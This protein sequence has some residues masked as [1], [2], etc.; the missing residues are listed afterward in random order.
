MN[1]VFLT[2]CIYQLVIRHIDPEQVLHSIC[3]TRTY[4]FAI[5]SL[6]W[7]KVV[8]RL[9]GSTGYLF[10]GLYTHTYV[11]TYITTL[12]A[13]AYLFPAL[14]EPSASHYIQGSGG[15]TSLEVL[16]ENRFVL[17]RCHWWV[18]LQTWKMVHTS[19][20]FWTCL[21]YVCLTEGNEVPLIHWSQCPNVCVVIMKHEFE[22]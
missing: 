3:Y 17:I 18:Y 7:N 6:L 20:K 11:H 4:I 21:R 16:E 2:L 12:S 9:I 14:S 10:W 22:F 19:W 8:V 15:L 5:N 1:N 13:T